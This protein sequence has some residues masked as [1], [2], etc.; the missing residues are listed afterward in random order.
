M[1][2]YYKGHTRGYDLDLELTFIMIEGEKCCV[3]TAGSIIMV[4]ST[5]GEQH[6]RENVSQHE[7]CFQG[8]GRMYPE[9]FSDRER[10]NA[11]W[12]AGGKPEDE[13]K[14]TTIEERRSERLAR[15]A[16]KPWDWQFGTK[17]E[18]DFPQGY[19]KV[20]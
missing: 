7:T 8:H 15:E 1:P 11:L 18:A 20:P 13:R 4:C 9:K 6:F 5:C 16:A 19:V 12:L 17:T 10:I 2:L 3:G 14:L